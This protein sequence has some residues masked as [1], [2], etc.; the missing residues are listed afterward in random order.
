MTIN[1]DIIKTLIEAQAR[2]GDQKVKLLTEALEKMRQ[3][4]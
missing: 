4:N 2:S 1:K 3:E